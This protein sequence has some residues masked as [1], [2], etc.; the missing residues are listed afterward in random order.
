MLQVVERAFLWPISTTYNSASRG[1][2]YASGATPIFVSDTVR[3]FVTLFAHGR[4][5]LINDLVY[6]VDP[7]DPSAKST[8]R[9][10]E[11]T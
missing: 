7:V 10:S 11:T 4:I 9:L 5:V 1:V 3:G 6:D 8:C 2:I